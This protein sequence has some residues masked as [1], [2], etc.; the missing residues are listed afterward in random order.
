MNGCVCLAWR[1]H[2][3][4]PCVDAVVCCEWNLSAEYI[5]NLDAP[6]YTCF[7]YH[8]I[9]AVHVLIG[10]KRLALFLIYIS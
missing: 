10:K 7:L 5:E 9:V 2:T 4:Q 8:G 3:C 6:S 1:C